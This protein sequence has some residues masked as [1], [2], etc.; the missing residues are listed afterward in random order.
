MD[1]KDYKASTIEKFRII[2]KSFYKIIYGKNKK[3]PKSVD[4]FPV[5]IGKDRLSKEKI[6]D[7]RAFRRKE[8]TKN[9]RMCTI[10]TKK[11]IYF[12]SL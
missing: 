5:S 12:L 2:L 1:K 8:D 9:N 3:Y 10:Y 7:F 4:W 6:I 11:S